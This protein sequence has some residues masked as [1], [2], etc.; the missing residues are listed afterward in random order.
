MSFIVQADWYLSGE[1]VLRN[2]SGQRQRRYGLAAATS[3]LLALAVAGQPAQAAGFNPLG[4]VWRGNGKIKLADGKSERLRCRAYYNPKGAGRRLRMA[5]RCASSS[6]KFELR[7]Q[8]ATDGHR[9][10]GTW[11]E[12]TF[13]AEGVLAGAIRPGRITL[14]TT[15]TI[16]ASLSVS[17][18][19]RRQTLQLGGNF[20]RF[21]GIT[22]ALRR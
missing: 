8:L 9:V 2:V 14:L 11:V 17:F 15:G 3:A 12:R 7:A 4:G 19:A 16:K 22:L 6:Y 1:Q 20:D 21:R 10:T 18:S 5:V 13:G